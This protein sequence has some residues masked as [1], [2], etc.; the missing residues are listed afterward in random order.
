MHK[1][2]VTNHFCFE[3]TVVFKNTRGA[4]A[5]TEK[6]VR[7]NTRN[8]SLLLQIFKQTLKSELLLH[9]FLFLYQ[10]YLPKKVFIFN[11]QGVGVQ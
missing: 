2:K 7:K 11:K 4:S 6:K 3:V 10:L 9:S 8:V 5:F 1:L